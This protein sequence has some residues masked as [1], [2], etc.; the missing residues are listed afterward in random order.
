MM[1]DAWDDYVRYAWGENELKPISQTGQDGGIY[2][3]SKIGATI[4]DSLDTLFIMGFYE[5]Y[6]K[7]RNWVAENFDFKTVNTSVSL[8]ETNIRILGGFLTAYALTRD[9]LYLDQANAVGQLLLPAFDTPS[10][11]PFDRINPATG[12][13]GGGATTSMAGLGTLHLEFAYLSEITANPVYADKV[14]KIRQILLGLEKPNGLYP[15]TVN[16]Q[17]GRFSDSHVSMGAG[18]D[19]FYEY[20]L[21]SWIQ[22]QDREARQMYNEAMDAF[23]A[24]DLVR[25]SKQSH[26]LYIGELSGTRI[27]DVGSHLEC[28]AGGMFA[29]G[30]VTTDPTIPGYG[31]RDRDME[32]GQNFTNTCHESYIRS[33]SH[34][35]PEVFRFTDTAEAV[36]V[37]DGEKYYILRPEVIESYFILYRLTKD[38]KYRDWAWDAAQAIEKYTKAGPGRG[39]SGLRN[40]YSSTPVQDD[41]QQTFFLAETLKYLYLV[42][43]TDDLIDLDKWVF[44]TECHPLPIRGKNPMF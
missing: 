13:T 35:G 33:D 8:F 5:E 44:N 28:F 18:A 37:N 23:V 6:I 4:I 30:S 19:S 31:N 15:N 9:D 1:K 2:G 39:Y 29:L 26:L 42:F 27:E 25:I 10:G 20:L 12:A 16:I 3:D 24:N 22:T 17:T 43:S 14:N 7:G 11:F 38:P 36:A 40:V 21:K 32:I 41:V 34:I